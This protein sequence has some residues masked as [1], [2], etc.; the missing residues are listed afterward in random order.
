MD[1]K[2][3]ESI[4]IYSREQVQIISTNPQIVYQ[5]A[6]KTYSIIVSNKNITFCLK[7]NENIIYK[8]VTLRQK[9]PAKRQ[10]IYSYLF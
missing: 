7:R 10:D 6:T 2:Q 3:L 8:N 4:K 5:N 1:F 9:T